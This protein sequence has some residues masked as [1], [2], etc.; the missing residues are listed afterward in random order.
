MGK[1]RGGETRERT[2]RNSPL[3]GLLSFTC[4]LTH[5]W[6][7]LELLH[8]QDVTLE[9]GHRKGTVSHS[10]KGLTLIQTTSISLQCSSH[11]TPKPL[12][13]GGWHYCKLLIGLNCAVLCKF[14]NT[15]MQPNG[16]VKDQ[17]RSFLTDELYACLHTVL[18]Q[19]RQM[20]SSKFCLP[21]VI[22]YACSNY[23]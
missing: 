17:R 16:L 23:Q 8:W 19:Q 20:G 9:K 22:T 1:K 13:T 15:L 12:E 7:P 3:R 14:Y 4:W 11:F 5:S 6:S 18:I 21:T 10:S 2:D